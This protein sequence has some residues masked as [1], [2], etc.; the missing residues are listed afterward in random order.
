[1]RMT[2]LKV[3][4]TSIVAAGFMAGTAFAGG[5]EKCK[6]KKN[7]T[8]ASV[9]STAQTTVLSASEKAQMAKTAK[10]VMSFDDALALC[11]KKGVTDL[12]ACIDYK[13]GKI[14]MKP[15]T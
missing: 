11:Q 15:Q 5:G 12:Q 6:D 9:T 2:S 8:T 13:T 7:T 14:A 3:L 1:M 10:T 4:G